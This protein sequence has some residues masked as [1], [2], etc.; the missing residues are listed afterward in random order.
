MMA[1]GSGA[2]GGNQV[3]KLESRPAGHLDFFE[4]RPHKKSD[5]LTVGRPER[6]IGAFSACERLCR[7]G[8]ERADPDE[9]HAIRRGSDKCQVTAIRRNDDRPWIMA[10]EM[11]P[12]VL[13]RWNECTDGMNLNRCLSEVTYD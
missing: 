3:A 6:T 2:T 8:I 5:P 11:K 10:G 4:R 7:D 1:P 13:R 12:G 9:I